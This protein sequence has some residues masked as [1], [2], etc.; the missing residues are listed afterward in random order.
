MSKGGTDTRRH[1]I[2]VTETMLTER[3][4][5]EIHL[6]DIAER[7]HVGVQTI[8]YHFDS[9]NQLIAEAQASTYGRLTEPLHEYLVSAEAALLDEDESE[10]WTA[11]G[12]NMMLAWSYGLTDDRWRIPKLMIDIASDAKTQREFSERLEIQLDRWINVVEKSKG[13]G[14]IDPEIDTY[15]LITACWAASIGQ[16]LFANSSKIYYTPQSIR[17]FFVNIAIKKH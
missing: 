16:A 14:W 6:A 3:Q 9:R 13:L 17:D 2:E 11:L 10:F 1:I 4:S 7:A 15:A 12:D 8:Y 5:G